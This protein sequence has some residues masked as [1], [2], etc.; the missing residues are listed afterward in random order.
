MAR[1]G[2][3]ILREEG[4]LTVTRRLPVRWDVAAEAVLPMADGALI[5]QQVRQDLWRL[6]RRQRGFAPAVRVARGERGLALRAGGRV[7]AAHDRGRLEARIGALLADPAHRARW[8]AAA[9]RRG[10]AGPPANPLSAEVGR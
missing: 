1:D 7:E 2:W 10:R 5:A 8:V 6:L 3:E 9:R 4:A